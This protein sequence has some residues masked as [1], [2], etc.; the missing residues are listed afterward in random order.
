MS[1]IKHMQDDKELTISKEE[2]STNKNR[3]KLKLTVLILLA[4]ILI[5]AFVYLY[6]R[7]DKTSRDQDARSQS[8]ITALHKKVSLL[9]KDLAKCRSILADNDTSTST[10]TSTTP[11][12]C[13]QPSASVVENVKASITSGN[14]AA[15]GGYMEA[16]VNVI[17][18]ATEGIGPSTHDQAIAAISNFITSDN[19]SWDYDFSLPA[20]T[21]DSYGSGDYSAYFPDGAVVGKA[22]NDR[23]ISFVFGC[24]GK[25]KT[26]FMSIASDI[27]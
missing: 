6:W 9:E 17:L 18:A 10:E 13:T 15:L 7:L 1:I 5:G 4:L 16:S 27:L 12:T 26:V 8:T 14:T 11:P 3:S 23:V 25:I 21:L 24:D 2:K 22:S 20:A 19:N